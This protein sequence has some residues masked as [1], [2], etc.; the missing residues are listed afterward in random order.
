MKPRPS[1]DNERLSDVLWFS[2]AGLRR[3]ASRYRASRRESGRARAT[4]IGEQLS[5]R[6]GFLQA[7]VLQWASRTASFSPADSVRRSPSIA[8]SPP[9]FYR[10]HQRRARLLTDL[11]TELRVTSR[12]ATARCGPSIRES[13]DHRGRDD[14]Q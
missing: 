5:T 1:V 9:N 3:R 10:R 4:V 11:L 2:L 8:D 14:T 12:H 7:S 13:A 6:L